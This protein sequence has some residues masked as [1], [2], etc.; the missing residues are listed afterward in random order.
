MGALDFGSGEDVV[1]WCL[2]C[3]RVGQESPVVVHHALETEELTSRF[4]RLVLLKVSHSFF[5]RLGALS[6]HLINE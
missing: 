4:G 6:G 2:M 3:C 5:Q 1:K